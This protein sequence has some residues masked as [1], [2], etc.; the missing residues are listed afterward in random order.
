MTS[1]TD[2][3]RCTP[4]EYGSPEYEA[5]LALRDAVLGKPLGLSF[6]PEQLKAERHDHHLACRGTAALSLA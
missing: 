2:N 1:A 5:A 3:L 6:S 4:I